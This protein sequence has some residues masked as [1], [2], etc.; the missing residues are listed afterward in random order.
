MSCEDDLG[1]GG[2]KESVLN[3]SRGVGDV[4]DKGGVG[5]EVVGGYVSDLGLLFR[6]A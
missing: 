3:G 6:G 4:G 2:V 5:H 1:V